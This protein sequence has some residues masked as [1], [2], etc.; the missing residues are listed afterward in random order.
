M[1]RGLTPPSNLT[2]GHTFPDIINLRFSSTDITY[3]DGS[4]QGTSLTASV[5][6]PRSNTTLA[7]KLLGH[8]DQLN[9]A[10]QAELVAIHQAL[11][12]TDVMT[13]LTIMTD[14]LTSIH[15][16]N[17]MLTRP[18]RLRLHKHKQVLS[19]I[20]QRLVART[21]KTTIHKVKAHVGIIGNEMADKAARQAHDDDS[22]P[23]VT[24]A[25]SSGRGSAWLKYAPDDTDTTILWDV[26]T[27]SAPM[28][29]SWQ[30]PHTPIAS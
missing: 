13:P 10:L 21:A 27:T 11:H 19:Q 5:H 24:V 12:N 28:L 29:P 3:T 22:T 20:A 2:Q 26:N 25:G 15:A 23:T 30:K 1:A 18:E 8:D 16:I 9:T 4:K 17:N 6:H 14:S 7:Y